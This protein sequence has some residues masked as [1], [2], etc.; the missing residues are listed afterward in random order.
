LG[1]ADNLSAR[2]KLHAAEVH[3]ALQPWDLVSELRRT[4]LQGTVAL[5]ESGARDLVVE[6]EVVELVHLALDLLAL[7][8]ESFECRHLDLHLLIGLLQVLS[9]LVF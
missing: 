2:Q 6:I 5:S 4:L 7:N 9:N 3:L 1:F 8:L